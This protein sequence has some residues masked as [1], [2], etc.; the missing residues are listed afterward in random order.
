MVDRWQLDLEDHKITSL[1]PDQDNLAN[2][3][4][5]K[6]KIARERRDR[7]L[8]GGQ[9]WRSRDLNFGLGLETR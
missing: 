7:M 3:I 2:K 6:L 1:S 9:G 4:K 5:T 8:H